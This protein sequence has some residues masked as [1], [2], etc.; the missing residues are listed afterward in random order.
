MI[1]FYIVPKIGDGLTPFT[2][3]RPA[4]VSDLGVP[5]GSMDYGREDTMLVGAEVTGAQHT[6]ISANGDVTSIP[7]NLDDTVSAGALPTVQTTLEGLKIP[8][9]WVT[10]SHTYR[11]VIGIV[12]RIFM[13]MQR[14]Y[15]L[16][17]AA[18]FFEPGITL[19]TRINQLTANQRN[20]L[21][22]AASALGLDTSFVTG[23]M[24]IRVVLKTWADAM[25]SFILAGEVF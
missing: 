22:A 6:A 25:G 9:G 5:F 1:R 24:T 11:Q 3:F 19:D 20:R 14:F 21:Q 15:G 4:Y 13:L 2:A 7:L 17:A 10:T 8:A 16:N 12:G 18:T 23:P